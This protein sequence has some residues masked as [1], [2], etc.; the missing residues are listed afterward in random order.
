[1]QVQCNLWVCTQIW[2]KYHQSHK[3]LHYRNEWGVGLEELEL[4]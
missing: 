3:Q 1:M 2:L 4:K